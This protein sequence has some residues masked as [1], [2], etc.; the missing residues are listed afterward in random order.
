MFLGEKKKK[1]IVKNSK[2]S[3][4]YNSCYSVFYFLTAK[5]RKKSI[6][7]ETGERLKRHWWNIFVK[8]GQDLY[9]EVFNGFNMSWQ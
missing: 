2:I 4:V 1:K 6:E 3:N 7:T 8:Q 9:P 5:L